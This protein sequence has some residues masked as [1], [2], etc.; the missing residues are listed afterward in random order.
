MTSTIPNFYA[1]NKKRQICLIFENFVSFTVSYNQVWYIR[2][3]CEMSHILRSIE[4]YMP[5]KLG[6]L[7]SHAQYVF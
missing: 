1:I 7:V 6:S 3:V 5:W 2:L 4:L